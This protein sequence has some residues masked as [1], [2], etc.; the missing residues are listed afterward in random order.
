MIKLP[1]KTAK[2]LP[3]PTGSITQ[4]FGENVQLYLDC[5]GL[6]GHNGIDW[7]A[8]HGTPLLAVEDG[9]IVE[10]KNS[11]NGYGKHV[12][13][14]SG[15]HEWV[16][17]HCYTIPVNVGDLIEAG[18]IIATMGNTGFVV[19]GP[20][21][22]WK[23]NPFAGT[24]LHLGLR[25]CKRIENE[26]EPHN[27]TYSSGHMG[28]IQNYD[29]GKKGAVDYSDLLP[30]PDFA[31]MVGK[32]RYGEKSMNVSDIQKK[33]GVIQTGYY[34]PI[35]AKAVLEWQLKNVVDSPEVLKSLGG[36]IFGPKSV[37]V[38]NKQ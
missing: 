35:T 23:F 29:N 11:P 9:I 8:S 15:E 5:C 17:G 24:H 32:A 25:I 28:M 6:H 3:Y 14:L 34:G 4:Y 33:L 18:D 2:F 16:Y 10:V 22:F 36:R 13:L 37:A 31:P 30:R 19:S 20:T 27:I 21:P 26:F 1:F 7:V 12:I 38:M